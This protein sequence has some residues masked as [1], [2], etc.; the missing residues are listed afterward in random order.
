MHTGSSAPEH[1]KALKKAGE[2]KK[3]SVGKG[4]KGKSASIAHS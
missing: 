2:E 4:D 3:S 1:K